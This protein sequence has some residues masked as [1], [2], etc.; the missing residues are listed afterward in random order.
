MPVQFWMKPYLFPSFLSFVDGSNSTAECLLADIP[1]IAAGLLGLGVL[2]FFLVMKKLTLATIFLFSSTLF[3]SF[4]PILDLS[5][6]LIRGQV[7]APTTSVAVAPLMVTREVF[8][9]ISAGLRFLFFWAL[10]AQCPRGEVSPAKGPPSPG[11]VPVLLSTFGHSGSWSRWGV[12]GILLK[13]TLAGASVAIFLLQILWRDVQEFHNLGTVYA[14]E[15]GL[16]IVVSAVL[17]VKLLLNTSIAETPSRWRTFLHYTPIIAALS[18]GMA[19]GI[20]NISYFAFTE[21]TLGRLLLAIEMYISIVSV[22]IS[23]F[24]PVSQSTPGIIIQ[25]EKRASSFQGLRLSFRDDPIRPMANGNPSGSGPLNSSLSRLSASGRRLSSWLIRQTSTGRTRPGFERDDERLWSREDV[26]S[27]I[28]PTS[29][30]Q[31][32]AVSYTTSPTEAKQS[33]R[34]QDPVFTSVLAESQRMD[35]TY[36]VN[37]PTMSQI[38]VSPQ[39]VQQMASSSRRGVTSAEVSAVPSYYR[40][41]NLTVIPPPPAAVTNRLSTNSP[42]FGL[43]G[44]IRDGRFSPIRSAVPVND[45]TSARSSGFEQLMREQVALEESIAQLGLFAPEVD[46]GTSSRT[47]VADPSV[48]RS[49]LPYDSSGGTGPVSSVKSEFSLSN[50]PQPPLVRRSS[51]NVQPSNLEGRQDSRSSID[52]EGLAIE[53]EMVPPRMPAVMSETGDM[54]LPSSTRT[55]EDTVLGP[56]MRSDSAGTQYDVTSFIGNLTIPGN[57]KGSSSLS[58]PPRNVDPDSEPDS[59]TSATIVTVQRKMSNPRSVEPLRTG[60]E[61][62]FSSTSDRLVPALAARAQRVQPPSRSA[63]ADDAVVIAPTSSFVSPRSTSRFSQSPSSSTFGTLARLSPPRP[64][65]APRR[66]VGLPPRPRLGISQPKVQ[67]LDVS[68]GPNAYERPRPAPS[69]VRF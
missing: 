6:I 31:V 65:A 5:Q 45:I 26:E 43:N 42:I 2:T 32:G 33:A 24:Y 39:A 46:E 25:G 57:N 23:T 61:R 35:K 15:G 22:L 63:S 14:T 68:P 60:D 64:L 12:I 47:S 21:S 11:K 36:P 59:A 56:K 41:S 16:E 7:D 19:L 49:S 20:G 30:N 8:Y 62:P 4:A 48:T 53:F 10:V 44:T 69:V 66:A 13:W 67:S 52:S 51:G 3:L 29:P 28:S 27:G 37:T 18:F 17:I 55:S 58:A 1:V 34:Y 9:S 50:F 40:N 38:P 54:Q